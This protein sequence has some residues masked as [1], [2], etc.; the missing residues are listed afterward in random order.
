MKIDSIGSIVSPRC[1]P[2]L[3][4]LKKAHF[5]ALFTNK[6]F[7]IHKIKK[8]RDKKLPKWD[9]SDRKFISQNV[10]VILDNL[11]E[12]ITSKAL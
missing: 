10:P 7:S 3:S 1:L 5:E 2:M 12:P 6:N 4:I 11:M 9:P 8:I